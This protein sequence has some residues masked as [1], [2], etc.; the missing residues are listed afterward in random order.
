MVQHRFVL[1]C[2]VYLPRIK[3]E[4]SEETVLRLRNYSQICVIRHY[5]QY[6]QFLIDKIGK[7]EKVKIR[8]V[9]IPLDKDNYN[10]VSKYA[11]VLIF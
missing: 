10:K 2:Q 3:Y 7:F 5:G 8:M 4:V 11:N 1:M 9:A 6:T